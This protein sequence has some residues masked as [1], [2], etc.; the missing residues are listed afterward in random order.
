MKV[1][2]RNHKHGGTRCI[3]QQ[4]TKTQIKMTTKNSRVMSCKVCQ[5]GYRSSSMDWL[6]KVFQNIDT[7][8]VLLMNHLW[9][10]EQKWYPVT[11]HFNS[12][13]ETA[14]QMKAKTIRDAKAKAS[15]WTWWKRISL[16]KQPQPYLSQTPSRIEALVH[17]KRGTV[18]HGCDNQFRVYKE[19]S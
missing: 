16:P 19:T 6:M 11:Q 5:I 3:D 10:R 12:F 13:T 15:R 8:P 18:D 2:A 4:K 7:L 14:I 9:S 1:R 17:F